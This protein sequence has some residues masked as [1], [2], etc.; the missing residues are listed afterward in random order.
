M[1]TTG[2]GDVMADD[3]LKIFK[4]RLTPKPSVANLSANAPAYE[5]F[6]T[7]D[8][9]KRLK[10]R[11]RGV[12]HSVSY[13]Y[14][15]DIAWD[16][17]NFTQIV[18]TVSGMTVTIDGTALGPIVDALSLETCDFLQEFLPEQFG[19]PVDRHAPVIT[20]IDVEVIRAQA[21]FPRKDKKDNHGEKETV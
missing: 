4:D 7:K 8:K 14:L 1:N 13:N 15:H 10:I 16:L 17:D 6:G 12:G 21:P 3:P 20:R 19:Q 18:L 9:V 5:A 2:K 11:T